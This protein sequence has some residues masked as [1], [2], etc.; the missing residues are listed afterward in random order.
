MSNYKNYLLRAMGV[1]EGQI[2][3]S[4][5]ERNAFPGID[6]HELSIGTED[7]RDEHDMSPEKARQTAVQ[8][9]ED[10]G[11]KHYY[12]GMAKAK[13]QGMLKDALLSPTAIAT[14]VIAVAVRGS[15]TGGLPSGADQKGDIS[16]TCLGGY[17]KIPVEPV[18]SKL[19]NKTPANPDIMQHDSPIVDDPALAGAVT[20][21]HQVQKDAG[22]EPQS[23]TGAST[24]SDDT[25][26]L[27]SAAPKGIDIDVAD[28]SNRDRAE[29][30]GANEDEIAEP[31][32]DVNETFARHKKLME[33]SLTDKFLS[34]S[35]HKAGCKCGFCANKGSFGKKDKAE[36]G[37]KEEE[38][39]GKVEKVEEKY[40]IPFEKMRGLA[41]L[42]ERRVA[43]NGLW[44]NAGASEPFNTHWKMDKEKGGMVKVDEE[45]QPEPYDQE[46]DQFAPGPRDRTEPSQ[47]T[48]KG[49]G[50]VPTEKLKSLKGVLSKKSKKGTLGDKELKLLKGIDAALKGRGEE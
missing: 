42:G 34:E 26:K 8:H 1:K 36:E 37:K 15:S 24:D 13:R 10:P 39:E 49:S 41:N 20:H 35:K 17:E 12:T 32:P 5:V 9:L 25:L 23:V 38:E 11:Q 22:Q 6:P 4:I 14:P 46:T 18:N 43:S 3:P 2:K 27:K 33:T 29:Y 31:R 19:V 21:P 16:P 44:E 7:E 48:T 30:S 28:E 47:P 40:S 50:K 45:S